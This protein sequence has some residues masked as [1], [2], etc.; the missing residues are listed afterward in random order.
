MF[1]LDKDSHTYYCD[2]RIVPG[3]T[4][5]IETVFR[6]FEDIDPLTLENAAER[7]KKVHKL[8]E[9]EDRGTLDESKLS[10]DGLMI[11]YL[12][13]WRKFKKDLQIKH[14]VLNE[15]PLHNSKL[16]YATTPDRFHENTI[17]EIK[18]GVYSRNWGLQLIGHELCIRQKFNIRSNKKLIRMAVQLFP[19]EYKLFPFA[20]G[21]DETVF[22]SMLNIYKY[23][24]GEIR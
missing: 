1:Y 21:R 15:E 16:G 18:T 9:F 22:K 20:D 5:I 11:R 10:P 4:S 23:I 7:G 19:N 2:G 13:T 8:L 6:T 12:N 24:K 14:F 3:L 17:Y